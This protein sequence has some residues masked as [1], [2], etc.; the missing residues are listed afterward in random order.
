MGIPVPNR[1]RHQPRAAVVALIALGALLV[2]AAGPVAF[3]AVQAWRSPTPPITRVTPLPNPF[4]KPS[5]AVSP[6]ASPTPSPAASPT[7]ASVIATL[8]GKI[9]ISGGQPGSGGWIQFP[10]GAFTADP[11][12]NVTLPGGNWGYGLAW[13][14]ATKAWV[15]VTWYQVRQ[16]GQL[17]VFS[18]WDSTGQRV[19]AVRRDGTTYMLAPLPQSPTYAFTILSAEP[20]GVYVSTLSGQGGL[21]LLD[22]AGGIRQVSPT[23]FWQLAAF[24]YAYGTVTPYVP[25]GATNVILRMNMK[26]G[27]YVEWFTRPGM[28]SHTVGVTVAGM[29]VIEATS[30]A[31]DEVWLGTQ[32]PKLLT[33]RPAPATVPGGQPGAYVSSALGDEVGIWVATSAGLYLYTDKAGWEFASPTTGMLASTIQ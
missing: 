22:Y 11:K 19:E 14:A 2:A 18:V 9:A 29:P 33:S 20:E 23:G 10:G 17:Y 8:N 31:T 24:G 28:Q 15:N 4:E 21:W 3:W 1:A 30:A 5:P 16:D 12:S 26:T 13:N 6:K 25:Q 32:V 27:V 7:P